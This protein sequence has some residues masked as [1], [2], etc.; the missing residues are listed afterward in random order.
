MRRDWSHPTRLSQAIMGVTISVTELASR[1]CGCVARALGAT[2]ERLCLSLR[3][4]V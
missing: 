2:L 4:K 1:K 3:R